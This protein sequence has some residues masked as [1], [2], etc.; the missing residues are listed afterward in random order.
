M[1]RK[2][3]LQ[4]MSRM[5]SLIL[6]LAALPFAVTVLEKK[7]NPQRQVASDQ[8]TAPT[9]LDADHDLSEASPEEFKKA[10]KYQLL[11]EAS[12]VKTNV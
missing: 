7:L 1:R 10:F 9:A 6:L 11:K 8:E 2:T 4:K 12:L 5:M 3:P